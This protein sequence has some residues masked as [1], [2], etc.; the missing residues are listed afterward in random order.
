M[1]NGSTVFEVF[2]RCVHAIHDGKLIRRESRQ[3]KEFH[4]QNW[5]Q[6]R[7]DETGFDNEAAGRNSFPDFRMVRF[8]EGYEVKGLSYPGREAN[9]DSNRFLPAT[10]TGAPSSISSVAIHRGPTATRTRCWIW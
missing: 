1:I 7:L 3:D 8:T 9:Y 4:F 5:V 2:D 6:A 10:T